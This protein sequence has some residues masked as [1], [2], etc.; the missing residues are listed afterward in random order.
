M[1]AKRSI[2]LSRVPERHKNRGEQRLVN[3][4]KQLAFK[5]CVTLKIL[6]SFDQM[7]FFSEQSILHKKSVFLKLVYDTDF[8]MLKTGTVSF[9]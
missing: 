4:P 6:F 2:Q 3:I 9:R 5:V 7:E 8:A 1:E